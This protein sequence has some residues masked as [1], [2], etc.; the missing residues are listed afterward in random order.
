ML[1]HWGLETQNFIG[2][3]TLEG[4]DTWMFNMQYEANKFMRMQVTRYYV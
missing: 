3:S 1:E 2:F 4:I